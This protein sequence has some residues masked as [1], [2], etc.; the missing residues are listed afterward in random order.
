MLTDK[1][2]EITDLTKGRPSN[3][4]SRRSEYLIWALQTSTIRKELGSNEKGFDSILAIFYINY[5]VYVIA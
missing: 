5:Y 1:D 2:L 3:E 4:S